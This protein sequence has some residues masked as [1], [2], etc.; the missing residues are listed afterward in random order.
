MTSPPALEVENTMPKPPQLAQQQ[1]LFPQGEA[2][3]EAAHCPKLCPRQL[4]LEPRT[5]QQVHQSR[6]RFSLAEGKAVNQSVLCCPCQGKQASPTSAAQPGG[7][8][9]GRTGAFLALLLRSTMC[10]SN[11]AVEEGGFFPPPA[12]SRN[13]LLPTE[14]GITHCNFLTQLLAPL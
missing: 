6:G 1:G 7:H 2:P 11:C 5:E 12:S 8:A 13:Q 10:L 14:A 9:P 4:L 3:S